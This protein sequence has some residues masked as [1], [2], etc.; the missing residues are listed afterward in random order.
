MK[1]YE[2]KA[3]EL[4]GDYGIPVPRGVLVTSGKDVKGLEYPV[5]VKAQVLIGGR[6]K[7]GGVK[8]A[9]SPEEAS[10][11]VDEIIGMD[12]HG[13]EVRKVL[14][15]E[16][17]EISKEYYLGIAIDR[18]ERAPLLMTSAEGG[19]EIES[20]PD[21]KIL[22]RHIPPFSV[23]P[24]YVL[25]DASKFLGLTREE[26]VEINPLALTPKGEFVAVDA[27]LISDDSA[28]YRHKELQGMEQDLTPLEKEAKSKGIV[29]IQL[30]GDIG[31]IANGAGLTMA[32]LDMISLK[33]GK[34]GVFLDLGGTD[35][36]EKVKEAF[37]LMK[38]AKPSVIF[39][40]IFGGIT[41]CDSVAQGVKEV[42]DEEGIDVPVVAR[43]KGVHEDEAKQILR[44]AGFVA[45]SSL[46]RAAEE[47]VRLR[48]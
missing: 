35:D 6:G 32:T 10:R 44:D 40:N 36:P 3:K 12:I 7:A 4:F 5:V 31:V 25:R 28:L 41:R 9:D 47:T 13:Y 14:V 39:L 46:E 42:L 45:V 33:G 19:V 26:L 8:F 22:K 1:F 15:E 37:R 43:I 23:L 29:F 11:A 2:Y 18:E 16:R 30:G 27:K 38:K 34:G 17:A 24:P 21:D 20:V 48:G